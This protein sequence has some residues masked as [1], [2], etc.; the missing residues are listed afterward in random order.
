M[1]RIKTP[2]E[3]DIMRRAGRITAAARSFAGKMIAPGVTTQEIDK[4]TEAFIRSQHAIPSCLGYGGFPASVCISVNDQVIHG[5]PGSR[6]IRDGDVV[7]IDLCAGFEGYIGDCAATFIAGKARREEDVKL[8]SITRQA[9][10]EGLKYARPGYRVSDISAAVQQ[11]V[12]AN[13]FS[14]IRDYVGHG[15]GRE[16]HEEPEVPNFGRPGHGPR[17]V[18]GMTICIEPMVAAGDWPVKVLE[19]DWTVVTRDG[20]N[21]AHYE[22]TVLITDGDPEIL[23][24]PEPEV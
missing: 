8:L 19:D 1:I 4:A 2:R 11:F 14:V 23:T 6:A 21:A 7:S 5:I 20:S 24:V 12:E 22:N 9:F 13:G 15:I 10:Y 17:L 3:I 18:R 16:M